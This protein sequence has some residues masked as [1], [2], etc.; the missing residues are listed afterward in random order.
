MAPVGLAGG[1]SK[2][3]TAGTGVPLQVFSNPP[4]DGWVCADL[5][6]TGTVSP[7]CSP[8]G[9]EGARPAGSEPGRR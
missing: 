1:T 6:G 9:A 7:A 5:L 4:E 3:L 2:E 8:A